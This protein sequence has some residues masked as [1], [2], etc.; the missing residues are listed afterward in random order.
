MDD[1]T[2]SLAFNKSSWFA[3]NIASM[4]G[5]RNAAFMSAPWATFLLFILDVLDK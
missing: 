4:T 2:R 1:G 3:W 5:M